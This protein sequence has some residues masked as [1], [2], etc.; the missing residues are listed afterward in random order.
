MF[1]QFDLQFFSLSNFIWTVF[2]FA[3]FGFSVCLH[4]FGHAIVAYWGGDRSVKAK[5]YLTLNP[6][7]YA[8]VTTSLVL[9]LIFL[10][11][12]G[13]PLPG[14]AVYINKAALKG[15]VWKSAVSAAGPL[16]TFVV[17]LEI[18]WLMAVLPTLNQLFPIPHEELLF[19]GLNLLL[20]LEV[21]G[22]ILNLIPIPGLDGYGI[23]EPWLPS[24][25]QRQ[26]RSYG[27][28]GVW[29]LFAA[30]WFVPS[31]SQGF[32]AIVQLIDR[33][34]GASPALT[35][36]GFARFRQGAQ[37]LFVLLIVGWVAY[38]KWRKRQPQS[39]RTAPDSTGDLQTQLA[40][41]E[42]QLEHS[43][44]ASTLSQKAWVLTKLERYGE[45]A[46][47]IEETLKLR[48]D[49]HS[50]WLLKG[51]IHQHLE[52]LPEAIAAYKLAL[53]LQPQDPDSW[54][55]LG[56]LYAH[57]QQYDEAIGAYDQAIHHNA[58]PTVHVS[59][60]HLK[61][62]AYFYLQRY[63]DCL[64]LLEEVFENDPKNADANYNKACCY[65][66][67]GQVELGIAALDL[68]LTENSAFRQQAQNDD[69]LMGLRSHPHF[70]ELV[71]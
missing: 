42:E 14:A 63:Q 29:I 46:T 58:D 22:V 44:E 1:D 67:L 38:D 10:L 45:A 26:F 57:L 43:W 71:S 35:A 12:G 48:S 70:S 52:Q 40:T 23:L 51:Y 13:I 28:Y 30:F 55:A 36:L 24:P 64:A 18:S 37:L 25:W 39:G 27:R 34:L 8:D 5:G 50:D 54:T 68:A 9:P 15:P 66:Q 33:P 17:A 61:S 16:A 6:L 20:T 60:L 53:N 11:M 21:A 3:G 19:Q 49:V 7:R 4:E 65:A 59:L 47:C 56:R 32:W 69:D 2:V 41:L 31:F 62:H